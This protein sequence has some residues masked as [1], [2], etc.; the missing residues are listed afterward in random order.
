MPAFSAA[1]GGVSDLQKALDWQRAAASEHI[2]A[3]FLADCYR[4]Y[5]DPVCL[6]DALA[7]Q[8]KAHDQAARAR[9]ALTM[10]I[11]GPY[12]DPPRVS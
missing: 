11:Y 7:A 6:S 8:M 3:A 4:K 12:Q 9:G 2:K 5:G 10:L 1:E